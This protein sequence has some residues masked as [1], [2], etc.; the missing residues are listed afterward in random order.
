MKARLVKPVKYDLTSRSSVFSPVSPISKTEIFYRILPDSSTSLL[1]KDFKELNVRLSS[2]SRRHI[3]DGRHE[4]S[5]IQ[6]LSDK[7]DEF[8][9]S[10]NVEK[11]ELQRLN[12]RLAEIAI[13]AI[14]AALDNIESYSYQYNV[15]II[16]V[17]EAS[18]SQPES[19]KETSGICVN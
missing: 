17:P 16:G 4:S 8:L 13:Q 14:E 2:G 15:K 1:S 6:F 10:Y 7:Y 19:S 18:N 12:S 9:S 11:K 5:S 3:D